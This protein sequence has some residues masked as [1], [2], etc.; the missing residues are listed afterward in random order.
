MEKTTERLA[1]LPMLVTASQNP[2]AASE[3][4]CMF[5]RTRGLAVLTSDTPCFFEHRAS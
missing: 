2:D 3:F 5:V 1:D 4:P